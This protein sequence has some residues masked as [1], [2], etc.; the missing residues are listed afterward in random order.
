MKTITI[1]L[2]DVEAAMLYELQKYDKKYSSLPSMLGGVIANGHLEK[3]D[4]PLR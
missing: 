1:R 3:Y 4:Q 2:S